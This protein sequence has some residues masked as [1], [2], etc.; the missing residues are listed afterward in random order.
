MKKIKIL[1]TFFLAGII[2]SCSSDETES[3][4]NAFNLKSAGSTTFKEISALED[5]Y[6]QIIV[7]SALNPDDKRQ[8]W[9]DKLDNFIANNDLDTDQKDFLF[10]LKTELNDERIFEDGNQIRVNF[11]KVRTPEIVVKSA[12]LFGKL[13][14]SYLL[15]KVENLNQRIYIL[16]NGGGSGTTNPPT[17][18][19]CDCESWDECYRLVS[20]SFDGLGWEYGACDTSNCF[21]QEYFFGFVESDNRGRCK[22]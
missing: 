1:A 19:S 7:A 8:L 4:N 5:T 11:L 16:N 20:I 9:Q 14:S 6:D 18:R 17:I 3:E 12:E 15:N 2:I 22:F 21:V 13:E 10:N